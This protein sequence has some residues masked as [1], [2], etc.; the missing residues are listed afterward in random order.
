MT[1][2]MF[3]HERVIGECLSRLWRYLSAVA[4][5]SFSAHLV[6]IVAEDNIGTLVSVIDE[7]C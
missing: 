4:S 2:L 7:E 3:V 5:F 1:F 6:Q